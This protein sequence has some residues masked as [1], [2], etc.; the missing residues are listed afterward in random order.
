MPKPKRSKNQ[1]LAALSAKDYRSLV[2]LLEQVPLKFGAIIYEPG[3]AIGH[4]YFPEIGI[5]S[6][7]SPVDA[8][9]TLEL[10]I[11]GDEGMVG[12]P[13][14][15]GVKKSLYL[16]I[17]QGSGTAVRITSRDLESACKT[18][19]SLSKVLQRYTHSFLT[20]ISQSAACNRFHPVDNRLARWLLMTHDR[21]HTDEFKITQEFLSNMLGVRR[22]AVNRA[23]VNLQ[24]KGLI[25]F[26]RGNL[27]V[28]SR[29]GLEKATCACYEV[30]RKE[31]TEL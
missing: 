8:N 21:M 18:A 4:A 6:L 10:G 30:I 28:L 1:L 26:S 7:L 19:T 13:I 25:T 20:Q 16:A 2:P 29:A 5:I 11:V 24:K 12:L 9:S 15:L 27:K 22:E 23:A 3:S 17:V 31:I 14:F